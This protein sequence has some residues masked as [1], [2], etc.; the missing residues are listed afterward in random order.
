[1]QKQIQMNNCA[2][3]IFFLFFTLPRFS[4]KRMPLW[5]KTYQPQT[6]Q[7]LFCNSVLNVDRQSCTPD[8]ST[9]CICSTNHI[10]EQA[11]A[12]K[13]LHFHCF[14]EL[15]YLTSSRFR[16]KHLPVGQVWSHTHATEKSRQLLLSCRK[17]G[18]LISSSEETI[19][20][21]ARAVLITVYF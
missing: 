9:T 7:L 20:S 19:H 8:V 17:S 14:W 21:S 3:K 4:F 10:T 12:K 6:R 16:W 1:M 15:F 5:G 13:K 11:A 18:T 2:R